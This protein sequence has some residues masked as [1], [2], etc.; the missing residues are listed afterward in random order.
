VSRAGTQAV[1][2][3]FARVH[4]TRPGYGYDGVPD[5]G[6]AEKAPADDGIY[7]ID[8]QTGAHRLIITLAAILDIDHKP[9]MDGAEH[10]FNHLQF[11]T[12]DSRFVFLH[13]WTREDGRGWHTRMMTAAP[14]GSA[15]CNVSDH[16]MVSHFDWRDAAKILAWATREGEG[17]HYFLFAD[18]GGGI[19]PVG[20]DVLDC[21]G[22]CSYSPDRRWVLTDT[23]PN[24]DRNRTLILYHPEKGHRVDIGSFHSPPELEGPWRCDLHPRW[25]RDG[26]LVC[27]DSA[28]EP[29][30]QI[31]VLDVSPVV[32]A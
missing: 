14:D 30:R 3:S 4:R 31:Y 8:L 10:W 2:L 20:T 12:D 26:R 28:H 29:T 23:Y 13:R 1:S 6:A 9:S 27:V 22:H 11:C 24:A 17:N 25:S 32:D 18:E 19:A 16:D 15:I 5:P 21:D 7:H